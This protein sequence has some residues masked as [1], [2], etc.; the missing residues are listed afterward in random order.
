MAAG[1]STSELSESQT[2]IHV[3]LGVYR[4]EALLIHQHICNANSCSVNLVP[5]VEAPLG[6]IRSTSHNRPLGNL[7]RS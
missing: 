1:S 3:A 6:R 4:E 2:H 7:S 5:G